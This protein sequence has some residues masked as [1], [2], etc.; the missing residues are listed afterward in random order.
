ML[1]ATSNRIRIPSS[2]FPEKSEVIGNCL[3]ISSVLSRTRFAVKFLVQMIMVRAILLLI[4][5]RTEL[6]A[7]R[8]KNL[9]H[10]QRAGTLLPDIE[11]CRQSRI[12]RFIYT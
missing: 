3:L 5:Y 8:S 2:F 10:L 12:S 9:L 7:V 4:L 6:A 11:G 1:S